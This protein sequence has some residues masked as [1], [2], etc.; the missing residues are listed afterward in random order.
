M[1]AK[2]MGFIF[3]K[4]IFSSIILKLNL[5]I[6]YVKNARKTRFIE[7]FAVLIPCDI[8]NLIRKLLWG[9]LQDF[10]ILN[11]STPFI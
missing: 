1:L 7:N 9:E 11:V 8:K 10:W 2:T 5:A 6:T 4:I 3:E